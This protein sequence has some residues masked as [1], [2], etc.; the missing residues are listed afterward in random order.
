MKTKKTKKNPAKTVR[1][2]NAYKQA[3]FRGTVK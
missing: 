2:T 1:M 3:M